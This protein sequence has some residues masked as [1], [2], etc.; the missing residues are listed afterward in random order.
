MADKLTLYID[1]WEVEGDLDDDDDDDE[2]PQPLQIPSKPKQITHTSL[3]PLA[4]VPLQST[5][6][7][8]NVN[9]ALH[10]KYAQE[11]KKMPVRVEICLEG[12]EGLCLACLCDGIESS[13][14]KTH[15]CL[16]WQRRKMGRQAFEWKKEHFCSGEHKGYC[17]KCLLNPDHVGMHPE[18]SGY[19][20]C[21]FDG[22]VF[23]L[24]WI[25]LGNQ[26]LLQSLA[27]YVDEP[28]LVSQSEYIEW[29]RGKFHDDRKWRNCAT[30]LVVWFYNT[31]R[32]PGKPV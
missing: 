23:E 19:G 12:L 16:R 2:Q 10:R 13:G 21:F 29:L 27:S 24:C 1:G 25:V 26:G 30:L 28:G 15:K 31:F 8:L 20:Q 5:S 22:I 32:C 3:A 9:T 17:Y 6:T 4:P 14:H 7:A 11:A 18:G